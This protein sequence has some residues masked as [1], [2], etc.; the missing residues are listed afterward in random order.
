[1]SLTR[2]GHQTGAAYLRIGCTKVL[3]RVEKT[4][5]FEGQS[6]PSKI[7]ITLNIRIAIEAILSNQL[8]CLLTFPGHFAH[9]FGLYSKFSLTSRC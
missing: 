9:F 1:M 3:Y 8:Q 2:H 5:T 6:V 7:I 4:S